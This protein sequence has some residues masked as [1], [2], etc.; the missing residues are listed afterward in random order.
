MIKIVREDITTARNCVIAHGVN[1]QGKMASGVAKAIKEKWP[2]VYD[3]FM[4]CETGAGMLGA[5]KFVRVEEDTVVFNCYTQFRYG[6][7]GKA[8]ANTRA[9]DQ[10]LRTV[11][12]FAEQTGQPVCIPKIGCGL[13][14]LDWDEDVKPIVEE[15]SQLFDVLVY[16]YEI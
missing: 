16:V 6:Y 7:D 11:F 9:I 12:Y 2:S 5:A 15:L 13:G 14:G 1:C 3:V 8:Y 4:Q 10:S